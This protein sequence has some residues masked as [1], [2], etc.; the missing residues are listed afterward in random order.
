VTFQSRF[1]RAQWLTPY[2]SEVLGALGAKGIPRV[3][4][5]CPGFVSDCLE[6]LEEIAIE[7]KELF[8]AGGGREF[9][10]IP[11]LN[12]RHPWIAALTDLVERNLAGW[13]VQPAPEALEK[14]R[15]NALSAGAL[16]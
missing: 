4:V 13:V 3:D 6:T 16:R 12:D 2:T 1:G 15:V 10:Y 5:V 11:C 14:S 7:G 9:H 8:L